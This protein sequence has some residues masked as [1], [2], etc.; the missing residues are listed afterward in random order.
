MVVF[1]STVVYSFN[2]LLWLLECVLVSALRVRNEAMPL[3][4]H[5]RDVSKLVNY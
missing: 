2:D 3:M 5:S 1:T 4:W